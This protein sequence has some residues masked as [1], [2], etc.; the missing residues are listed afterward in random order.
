MST[1]ASPA[2]RGDRRARPFRARR[3]AGGDGAGDAALAGAGGGRHRRGQSCA[4]WSAVRRSAPARWPPRTKGGRAA[5][6]R[7]RDGVL[8]F[9]TPLLRAV[10]QPD[11]QRRGR[12]YAPLHRPGLP[13]DAFPAHRSGGDHAGDRRRPRPLGPQQELRAGH[14][15]DPRRLCRAGREPRRR[16]RA[17][18]ARGDRDRGQR[19]ALPFLA[20]LAVPGQH[21]AR[22]LRRCGVERDHGRLRRIGGRPL[23]RARLAV[24]PCRR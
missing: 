12:A 5:G 21:H 8:A 14:V 2:A 13:C 23:V 11:A 24:E 16:R 19:G 22:L 20:A 10:R 4:N 6:L 15:F 7:P 17:R 9:A 3:L 1:S 18:G